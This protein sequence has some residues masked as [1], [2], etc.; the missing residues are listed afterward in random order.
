MNNYIACAS[1]LFSKHWVLADIISE[2]YIGDF[3]SFV[4]KKWGREKEKEKMCWQYSI[5]GGFFHWEW[6]DG[7]FKSDI[8]T[9]SEQHF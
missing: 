1:Q 5:N 6:L 7:Y 2:Y 8:S 3:F 9:N 4:R